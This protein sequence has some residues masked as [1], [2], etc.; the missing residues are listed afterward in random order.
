MEPNKRQERQREFTIY[1]VLFILL[2]IVGAVGYNH[3]YPN[4]YYGGVPVGPY[5]Y[6]GY[7]YGGPVAYGGFYGPGP[8]PIYWGGPFAGGFHQVPYGPP[9]PGW[10]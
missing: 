7:P 1:L 3:P 9:A 4:Y 2:V 5:G 10:W 8:A 6:G